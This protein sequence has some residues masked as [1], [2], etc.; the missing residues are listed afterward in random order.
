MG[1]VGSSI[2]TSQMIK[3]SL[4][5]NWAERQLSLQTVG[6][7]PT[8]KQNVDLSYVIWACRKKLYTCALLSG[9]ENGKAV[10]PSCHFVIYWNSWRN[11]TFTVQF[12]IT[13][14][15][16][17]WNFTSIYLF[18]TWKVKSVYHFIIASLDNWSLHLAVLNPNESEQ[19]YRIYIHRC[20]NCIWLTD[21]YMY[22]VNSWSSHTKWVSNDQERLPPSIRP[23]WVE[24]FFPFTWWSKKI[25]FQNTVFAETQNIS[26]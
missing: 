3:R 11:S 19:K 14:S 24:P 6:L 5:E 10:S 15:V 26:Q 18:H 22:T 9:K 4:M 16:R 17:S 25:H 1:S 7:I 13:A 23:N 8:L 20:M 12:F 2:G 21:I